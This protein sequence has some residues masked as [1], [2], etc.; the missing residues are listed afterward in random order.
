MRCVNGSYVLM[1]VYVDE[2]WMD[3]GENIYPTEGY[4]EAKNFTDDIDI[5]SGLYGILW[6]KV[7][8]FPYEKVEK[9]NWLV[10]K[11]E[12]REDLI[13]TDWESERYKFRNGVVV[14]AGNLR[15]SS[16]YIMKHKD[17]IEFIED[18][19]WI[20]SEEV[21]GTKEWLKEH[22]IHS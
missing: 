13:K 14:Y 7:N 18:A 10:I 20:R 3:I 19:G 6:G 22:G 15:G 4:V 5:R 1:L 2:N 9:G 11:T 12:L 16:K 21:A 17:D 8:I